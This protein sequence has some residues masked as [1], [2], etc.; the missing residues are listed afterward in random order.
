MK[1]NKNGFFMAETIVIIAVVAVVLLGVYK[2]FNS[3]YYRYIETENYNTENAINALANIQRY[4]ES[5]GIIDTSIVENEVYIDITN[6]E[7][8]QSEFYTKI[9]EEFDVDFIYLFNLSNLNDTSGFNYLLRRYL[10]TIKNKSNYAIVISVRGGEFTHIQLE[11]GKEV[12]LVGNKDDEYAVYLSVGTEFTDP[13][14]INW[15]GDEPTTSWEGDNEIDINKKGTYYL[16]Y[17]FNGIL[18]R[19]KIVVGDL[20]EEFDY[21]GGEQTFTAD[22]SGYYKLEVWGAQGGTGMADAVSKNIGGYGGYSTGEIYLNKGET[23]YINVGGKGEDAKNQQYGG[24]GGYNGGG[25]GGTDANYS[26]SGGNEPGG[27]GGGATHISK[28]TGLLSTYTTGTLSNL[29]IVAGGGGGG[30]YGGAGGTADAKSGAGGSGYI[31][32]TLLS[33]K[34]MYCY[35]CTESSDVSTKTTT[36]TYYSEIPTSNYAKSG[37][38]YAKI[39]LVE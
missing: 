23:I 6:D 28:T 5:K 2:Q 13:G 35:N 39:S 17:N 7:K 12:R 20:S 19:R 29:I 22:I 3:V 38:G 9:K 36:T 24:T 33:E 32:N 16:H 8:Y 34:G 14:Y 18:L 11:E 21:T 26:S 4:Y 15:D 27:A 25:N 30:L 37:N 1:K 31:A 10:D